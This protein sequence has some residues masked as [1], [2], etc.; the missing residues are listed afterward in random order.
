MPWLLILWWHSG[1]ARLQSKAER[2][3]SEAAK[4]D[5]LLAEEKREREKREQVI[6]FKETRL[7]QLRRRLEKLQEKIREMNA[8]HTSLEAFIGEAAAC[9]PAVC[10]PRPA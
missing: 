10:S 5:S 7:Q 6:S 9:N 2:A 4:L 3:Q 8:K 1:C